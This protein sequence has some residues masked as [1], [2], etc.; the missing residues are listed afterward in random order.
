MNLVPVNGKSIA[1]QHPRRAH[2]FVGR[3]RLDTPKGTRSTISQS[4]S[5]RDSRGDA[6]DFKDASL[7]NTYVKAVAHGRL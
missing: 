5:S 4:F 7:D 6:R 3:K 2:A 1:R